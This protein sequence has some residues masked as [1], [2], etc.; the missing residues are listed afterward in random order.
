[1]VCYTSPCT[2]AFTKIILDDSMH[3]TIEPDV[4]EHNDVQLHL[5]FKS[6]QLLTLIWV[7][8]LNRVMM[9]L[10]ATIHVLLAQRSKAQV[11]YLKWT[12]TVSYVFLCLNNL[13]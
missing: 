11:I 6:K 2:A 3:L 10:E 5:S 7:G 13:G 1:M 4:I 12:C 9:E 8:W